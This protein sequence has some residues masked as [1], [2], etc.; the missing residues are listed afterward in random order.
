MDVEVARS[1]LGGMLSRRPLLLFLF[2][3]PAAC[4]QDADPQQAP[5]DQAISCEYQHFPCNPNEPSSTAYCAWACGYTAYCHDY[6]TPEVMFCIRHP[7]GVYK[8]SP[9]RQCTLS[10][11][12]W[13]DTW[14][15][16]DYVASPPRASAE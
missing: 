16:P 10:G 6:T 8:W 9:F 12:P 15:A 1:Y 5:I 7:G 2:L 3:Y 14:C 4:I 13:W 11:D